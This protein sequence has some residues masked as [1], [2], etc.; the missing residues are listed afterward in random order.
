MG[1]EDGTHTPTLSFQ[2]RIVIE[3]YWTGGSRSLKNR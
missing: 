3:K 2:C 1:G